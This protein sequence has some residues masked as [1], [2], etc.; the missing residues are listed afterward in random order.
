MKGCENGCSTWDVVAVVAD[1][2]KEG[3]YF[4][5]GLKLFGPTGDGCGELGI[6]GTEATGGDDMSKALDTGEVEDALRGLG[7]DTS[8][9]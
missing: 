8:V 4:G 6:D 2:T 7:Y 9:Q 3:V 1:D 5:P